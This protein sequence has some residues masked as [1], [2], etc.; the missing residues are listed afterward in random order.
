[1][2]HLQDKDI[3]QLFNQRFADLEVAPSA[4]SWKKITNALDKTDKK[5][6]PYPVWMAAASAAIL[7]AASLW[8]YKPTEIIKLQGKPETQIAAKNHERPLVAETLT[9]SHSKIEDAISAQKK[10]V[11]I[12][13][14]LPSPHTELYVEQVFTPKKAE[15]DY[16]E[17][18]IKSPVVLARQQD[19]SSFK[20][21]ENITVPIKEA[22]VFITETEVFKAEDSRAEEISKPRIKSVGGLVNFVIAQVDKR[23]DKIIEFKDGEEGSEVSGVNIG[24]LKFK[25]RQR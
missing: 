12:K 18:L 14:E 6:Y 7:V 15:K 9:N 22:P 4:D 10:P 20:N 16:S 13:K 25:S 21:L 8:L 1:M 24:L 19:K 5:R 2:E 17:N 23:E 3:N 11:Q